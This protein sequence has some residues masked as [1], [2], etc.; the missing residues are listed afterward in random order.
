MTKPA[1]QDANATNVPPAEASGA[2]PFG[3]SPWLKQM[4]DVSRHPLMANPVTA[5]AAT[6]ALGFSIAG[7]MATMMLGVMQS[8]AEQTRAALDEAA[9]QAA[10]AQAEEAKV[11]TVKAKPELR[12][13]P[14][15]PVAKAETPVA[16]Q[17]VKVARDKNATPKTA[18]AKPVRKAPAKAAKTDDLKVISGIGPKLEQVLNGMGF[19][20]YAD[21][22]AL[23]ASDVARIEA[24]LGFSGRIARDGWVEQAKT[25]VKGRG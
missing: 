9:E 15:E 1:G 20:R 3:F 8:A 19:K 4:P 16:E 10:K 11:E 22:A 7:Q 25:L 21:I 23:A 5:I 12:V 18:D 17:R 13:V 14:N 24:E 6:T 2:D